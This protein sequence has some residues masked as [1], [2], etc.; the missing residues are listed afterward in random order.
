MVFRFGQVFFQHFAHDT[1]HL[2][3]IVIGHPL[4]DRRHDIIVREFLQED[5]HR[6]FIGLPVHAIAEKTIKRFYELMR[7]LCHHDT[8]FQMFLNVP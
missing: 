3:K 1:K 8:R 2:G 4:D 6:V 5:L 7:M